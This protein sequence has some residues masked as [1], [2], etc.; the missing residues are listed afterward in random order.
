MSGARAPQALEGTSWQAWASYRSSIVGTAYCRAGGPARCGGGIASAARAGPFAACAAV[1][2]RSC[3]DPPL[4]LQGELVRQHVASGLRH[5][6]VLSN[7]HAHARMPRLAAQSP[8]AVLRSYVFYSE[9]AATVYLLVILRAEPPHRRP[10]RARPLRQLLHPAPVA[11]AAAGAAA[12]AQ[13]AAAAADRRAS[14]VLLGQAAGVCAEGVRVR[15]GQDAGLAG[16][17]RARPDACMRCTDACGAQKNALCP[18]TPLLG[19]SEQWWSGARSC[20]AE[21]CKVAL[22]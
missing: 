22:L 8:P 20:L 9:A 4:G 3:K 2:G 7:L 21:R 6:C 15:A 14:S 11:W 16:A 10:G 13:G 18:R 1:C 17:V 5:Y 12:G 19:K